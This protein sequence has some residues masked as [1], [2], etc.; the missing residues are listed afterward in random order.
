MLNLVLGAV[1]IMCMRICDVTFGTFRILLVSQGKKYH[2]GIAGFFE[3]LIWIFAMRYIVQHMDQNINLF[4]YALGYALGNILGITLEQRVALGYSQINIISRHH[5][6]V[7]ADKLRMAK[8]GVTILPAEG[9]AG[10]VSILIVIIK[11]KFLKDLMKIVESTDKH[12][13]ITVQQS[14][15]FRGY[16]H[17]S[18]V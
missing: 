18:R 13:F 8:F 12:A 2:A 15:P 6:D 3:V 4:G 14:Q 16:I 1:L 9:S 7:I 5:T 11:R 10:G 17:G